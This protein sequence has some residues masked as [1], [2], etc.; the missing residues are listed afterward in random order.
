MESSKNAL[1]RIVTAVSNLTHLAQ[2]AAVD[3]LSDAEEKL[4]AEIHCTA[5]IR[6]MPWMT[7]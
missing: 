4:L 1:E 6:K 2:E 5:K 3:V 7:I